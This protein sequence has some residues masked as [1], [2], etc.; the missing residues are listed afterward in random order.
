MAKQRSEWIRKS[1]LN[2]CPIYSCDCLVCASAFASAFAL[3]K[4]AFAWAIFFSTSAFAFSTSAF[5]SANPFSA[6][7]FA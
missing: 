7:A 2:L 4:S 3:S 5:T 1:L 6:S